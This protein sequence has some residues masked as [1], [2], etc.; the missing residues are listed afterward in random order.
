M[1]SVRCRKQTGK[2]F[3][4]FKFRGIRCRE[5]TALPD[6]RE[7]RKKLE[8]VATKI[9]ASITLGQF[10]YADYFPQSKMVEKFEQRANHV[11]SL[12]SGEG[13]P[14]LSQFKEL[15]SAEMM[16]T[17]RNSYQGSI[18]S[19]FECHILPVFGDKV[20]SHI[21][22]A[23]VLQF[24]AR[25]AKA[26]PETGKERKATTV[27]KILK[28]FRLMI[29][30]AADRFHFSNP[31]DG[32]KMLKEKK[33]DI[34]PLSF[35][36][37]NL[38]LKHVR[39]DFH[40]YFMVRFYS[41]MRSGEVTGLRWQH[42]DFDRAQILVRE[43][44]VRGRVEYTK[45]DG[46]YREIDITSPLLD[47]LHRQYTV[48]GTGDYVFCNRNGGFLDNR[49]VCNRVWYPMLDYLGL[50]R[51][52][53]YETR[54]TAA[55]L[56]MAAGENPEWIARQLGHVNTEMLFKVYSRYVPNLTRQDG[57]AFEALIREKQG[58]VL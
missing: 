15:W 31:F 58:V 54:H 11:K 26:S 49:N 37:V 34:Q 29:R 2:L 8:T 27:N 33:T 47:A 3:I 39:S 45:N 32:V 56:W 48:T 57:S 35:K 44:I 13:T 40:D 16:P 30:E 20:V 42:V 17:W 18:E 6:T 41:G 14:T 50:P 53:L 38:F 43:T 52:R 28:I 55:T 24:R 23:D 1:A 22:K 7:N 19:I 46:S 51:R 25:L 10:N 12:A 5:Q 36:E 4:D 21:T 9:E